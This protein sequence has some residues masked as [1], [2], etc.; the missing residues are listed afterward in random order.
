[1]GF[2]KKSAPAVWQELGSWYCA[3]QACD[4]SMSGTAPWSGG[5]RRVSFP[6]NIHA[7][8]YPSEVR[9]QKLAGPRPGASCNHVSLREECFGLW[10]LG[11]GLWGE[12]LLTGGWSRG[13]RGEQGPMYIHVPGKCTYVHVHSQCKVEFSYVVMWCVHVCV[14]TS[15]CVLRA[16]Q[17]KR[18]SV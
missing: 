10:A 9:Q 1:M 11:C 2:S 14:R 15:Y 18:L 17:I 7:D 16:R 13:E 8:V 12:I 6:V 4:S 3:K 5:S